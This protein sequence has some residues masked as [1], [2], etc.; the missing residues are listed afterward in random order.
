MDGN[1]FIIQKQSSQFGVSQKNLKLPERYGILVSFSHPYGNW[2]I[3][4][5][6][7]ALEKPLISLLWLFSTVVIS[8][9]ILRLLTV[10]FRN[11]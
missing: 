11:F 1:I 10:F 8:I 6:N 2:C 7:V 9:F 5:R 3:C 4:H